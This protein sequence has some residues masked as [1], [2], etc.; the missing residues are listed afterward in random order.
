MYESRLPRADVG[1]EGISWFPIL[2]TGDACEEQRS[3]QFEKLLLVMKLE[4][5][6]KWGLVGFDVSR[7]QFHLPL[8]SFRED[9]D[10]LLVDQTDG[11]R[12]RCWRENNQHETRRSVTEI[13]QPAEI[14]TITSHGNINR[15]MSTEPRGGSILREA[16][17]RASADWFGSS[18]TIVAVVCR[19]WWVVVFF[20][21]T[22]HE[23]ETRSLPG[24]LMR[25]PFLRDAWWCGGCGAQP[26][27]AWPSRELG[28]L[29]AVQKQRSNTP[30]IPVASLLWFA[31]APWSRVGHLGST[32]QWAQHRAR[33]Q[34]TS[35]RVESSRGRAHTSDRAG[36]EHNQE[37]VVVA[38]GRKKAARFQPFTARAV[39]DLSFRVRALAP[40]QSKASSPDTWATTLQHSRSAP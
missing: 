29:L 24:S 5:L 12:E 19:G 21:W 23:G 38:G 25:S 4:S 26:L 39:W 3:R 9:G 27:A 13:P 14:P 34:R 28:W 22:N 2:M 40:V 16:A 20:C 33:T 15:A 11:L 36:H 35:S 6:R 1:R 7:V 37:A 31:N 30:R 18:G 8:G 32:S 17:R 10:E